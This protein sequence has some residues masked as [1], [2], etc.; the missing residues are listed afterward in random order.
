[1]E[2]NRNENGY[3]NN[4]TDIGSVTDSN[5]E[6]TQANQGYTVTPEG[7]YYNHQRNDII[8][9]PPVRQS[10][11]A[12]YNAG[13]NNTAQNTV[14]GNNASQPSYGNPYNSGY[15]P[16][17]TGTTPPQSFNNKP[18]K[19]KRSYG[20]GIV[21]VASLLA[22]VI[23][24]VGGVTATMLTADKEETPTQIVSSESSGANVNITVDKTT[25]S[26]VEA[27][28]E[29]AS[30]SV[31]GIRTTTSVNNFFY[32][33]SESTGEGSGVIYSSDGYIITNYHVIE[34]VVEAT[35]SAKIEVFIGDTDTTSHEATVVGYSISSDLAVLKIN[36]TGLT[37]VE[38]GSSDEL[39][40]GQFVVTIGSP[41][42]LDFRGSVTYGVISGLD[43]VVSGD[44]DVKLIQTDAAINPGNSGGALLDTN[45]KLIG[46]NSSKIVSTEYEGM[47]FAI[48]VST[49]I[50][51]CDKII[52]KQ[53]EPEPYIGISLSMKYTEEVLSYYGFPNG[54]VVLSVDEG[55]PAEAAGIRR[56]DIITEFDGEE[57][58]SAALLEEMIAECEPGKSVKVKIY[59][60]GRYYSTSIEVISNN[61]Q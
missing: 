26:V 32:G 46:I 50:E 8:Q 25:E 1:M 54:A 28:A 18:K 56:G 2:E 57:V 61:T 9:D 5:A 37:P 41:G 12:S 4:E 17:H 44:E 47:G 35:S 52:S 3:I 48:P 10:T 14:N 59:R 11:G 36:V 27:V 30:G 6:Q 20:V 38:I 39:K 43:R 13:V 29:K 45:G 22:A 24:A 53:N 51:K 23:G 19:E 60:S 7:G 58:E 42:G 33:N 40:V 49:V 16:Y 31:V 15:T 34:S 55:G 21:L